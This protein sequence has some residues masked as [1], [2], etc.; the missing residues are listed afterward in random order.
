MSDMQVDRP[1]PSMN[2]SATSGVAEKVGTTRVDSP[3]LGVPHI[4]GFGATGS[5][6]RPEAN[7]SG[8]P[9]RGDVIEAVRP[10]AFR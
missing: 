9:E 8:N 7:N 2:A 5:V 3:K 1:S 10:R 4:N 6:T